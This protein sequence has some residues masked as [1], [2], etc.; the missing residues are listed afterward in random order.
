VSLNRRVQAD[1]WII[2]LS[3][4]WGCTFV[5]I[6][7]ALDDISPLLFILAR[8]SI[9]AVVLRF[10]VRPGTLTGGAAVGGAVIGLLLFTGFAAQTIGIQFTTAARSAF[11]TGMYLVFTPLLGILVKRRWPSADAL[12]GVMLATAGMYLLTRPSD[13][14]GGFGAGEALTLLCAV[15]FAGHLLAVDHYTRRHDPSA[16]AFLQVA[17]VAV[18]ALPSMALFETPRFAAT[19]RLLASL[20]VTSLLAT[21]AG[22][23]ILSTVQ[24]W[25]TP[26]RAAIIFAAEPVFAAFTSWIAEG[27]RLTRSALLGAGLIVMGML[28]AELS[29][30][31]RRRARE[32][33][34]V[35]GG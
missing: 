34:R 31:S 12:L 33:V 29:P 5:V 22:F 6:K 27:E 10:A 30:F 16:I 35:S 20:A 3:A 1:L 21:A 26:T 13:A 4:I 25:T 7:R 17:V 8:F 32:A 14:G 9:A 18:L 19:P 28:A 2:V 11:I 23:L 24:S 15:A